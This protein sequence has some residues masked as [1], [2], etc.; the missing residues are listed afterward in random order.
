MIFDPG[1]PSGIF[2]TFNINSSCMEIRR[3]VLEYEVHAS[4]DALEAGDAELLALA[5][6]ATADAYAP[7]SRFRVAACGRMANGVILTG[8]NQENASF[9]AGICAERS[10]LALAAALH[11]GMPMEAM[12]VSYRKEGEE[13]AVPVAP[14]GVCRQSIREFTDRTGTPIRLILGGE[15]GEVY[16][17]GS[18]D[19]LLPLAFGSGNLR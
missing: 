17:M 5:R 4:I 12:A 8:T 1:Q 7:Y 6:K 19:G 10:L 11:P 3:Q 13:G 2:F 16:V 9:P 15:R 18:A 14:C